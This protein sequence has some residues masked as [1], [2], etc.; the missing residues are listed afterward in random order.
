[1]EKNGYTPVGYF[2]LSQDSWIETYYKP[3][4]ARFGDFLKRTN[5]SKHTRKVVE[6]NQAEIDLYQKFKDY[7]SYGFFIVRKNE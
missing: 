3:I 2:S 6:D 4:Q 5:N 7:Y 1:L